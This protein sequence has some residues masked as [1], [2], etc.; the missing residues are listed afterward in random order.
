MDISRATYYRIIK[1][2]DHAA[3]PAAAKVKRASSRALSDDERE[4]VLTVLHEDRFIDR[5]PAAIYAALLDDGIYWCSPRTMYRILDANSEVKERRNQLR[6]PSYAKPELLATGPNQVWSWDVT[7]LK[8]P[9]KGKVYYLYVVIDIFSRYVVGWMVASRESAD[10][11]S[12]LINQTCKRQFIDQG[13]LVIHSDRGAPMTSKSLA[14]LMSK[15]G[16]TKSLSR[17]YVSDDNPYSESGF[18]TLKYHPTFPERFGCLEDSIAF[19]RSYF[20]WYNDEHYHSNIA[21]MTPYVVHHGLADECNQK[22]QLVLNDAFANNPH[23]FVNGAPTT[24]ELPRAVWINRPETKS[25]SDT[26]SSVAIIG[27][28]EVSVL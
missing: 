3:E 18:K 21:W 27:K 4:N 23:R 19:C 9:V 6:H 25:E 15:L 5:A 1:T 20:D 17:P 10:L 8:G 7:K 13:Q 22:R 28:T 2:P 11:A 12:L 16:V 24:R 14:L 26:I